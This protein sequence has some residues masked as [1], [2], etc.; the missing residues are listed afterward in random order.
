MLS[1]E[2]LEIKDR[3]KLSEEGSDQTLEQIG[4]GSIIRAQTMVN[5]DKLFAE[6]SEEVTKKVSELY[7]NKWKV[8]MIE[9][10]ENGGNKKNV[11][12]L[13]KILEN[14]YSFC[15]R[16]ERRF[17]EEFEQAMLNAASNIKMF[18]RQYSEYQEYRT[19]EPVHTYITEALSLS[20][21]MVT[22]NPRVFIS[23]II[24]RESHSQFYDSNS[25][26]GS[27]VDYVVLPIVKWSTNENENE[28]IHKG[29]ATFK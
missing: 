5:Y 15:E 27:E 18:L 16:M 24:P 10:G 26:N 21:F 1:V 9:L 29:I 28:I 2:K 11:E 6:K 7:E 20:W 17:A 3:L 22:R 19:K 25:T 13:L 14:A 12:F 4:K 8:A 23:T